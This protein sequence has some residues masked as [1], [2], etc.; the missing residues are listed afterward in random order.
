MRNL[1]LNVARCVQL[2]EEI[3]HLAASLRLL[4]RESRRRLPSPGMTNFGAAL[5][6]FRCNF[7]WCLLAPRLP[8][9]AELS[10]AEATVPP[11]QSR[12][13]SWLKPPWAQLSK[14]TTIYARYKYFA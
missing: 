13:P 10:P 12:L 3:E 6:R 1:P 5:I 4:G 8:F 2:V 7:A 14:T 11:R 9:L